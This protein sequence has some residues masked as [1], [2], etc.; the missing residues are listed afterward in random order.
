MATKQLPGDPPYL[1]VATVEDLPRHGQAPYQGGWVRFESLA[2]IVETD[3]ADEPSLGRHSAS[4][5]GL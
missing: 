2:E 5:T 4:T 1:W 3:Q